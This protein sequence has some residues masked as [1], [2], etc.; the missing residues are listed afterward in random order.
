MLH[1]LRDR[2]P[3]VYVS[4]QHGLDQ[5]NVLLAHDPWDSEFT[6]H[7]L[8]DAIEWVLLVNDRVEKDPKRPH[9][10]LFAPVRTPLKDFGRRVICRVTISVTVYASKRWILPMVPTKT[11]NGPFLMYAALP[12]S[13]SLISPS[14][15]RITFS[16]LMSLCTTIA[17]VCR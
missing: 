4:F 16:S 9:V 13:I 17:L 6:V 2:Q 14:P 12:K 8:V 5:I 15:S 11:S 10:L 7:D 1:D 3:L